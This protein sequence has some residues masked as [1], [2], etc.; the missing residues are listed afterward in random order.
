MFYLTNRDIQSAFY[1]S[2][3]I[4]VF[5]RREP[6]LCTARNALLYTTVLRVS[7]ARRFRKLPVSKNPEA[8]RTGSPSQ[9]LYIPLRTTT[10]L[11]RF[12]DFAGLPYNKRRQAG[13]RLSSG[14]ASKPESLSTSRAHAVLWH[15]CNRYHLGAGVLS[16]RVC[17]IGD[18]EIWRR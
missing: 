14:R 3:K 10:H 6:F 9:G 15:T 4:S 13:E 16:R 17:V 11:Q 7:H 1:L 8:T 5:S 18:Y 12:P 2:L